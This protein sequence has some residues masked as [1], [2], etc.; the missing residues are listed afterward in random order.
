MRKCL[1]TLP[2]FNII[3]FIYIFFDLKSMPGRFLALRSE[4]L[5]Y[6][7]NRTLQRV[8]SFLSLA[9]TD[10]GTLTSFVFNPGNWQESRRWFN[11]ALKPKVLN[12]VLNF[13]CVVYACE[14]D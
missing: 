12:L 9:P 13:E 6:E 10:F 14:C 2:L 4:D 1:P 8:L 5:F 7:T 3:F 11:R